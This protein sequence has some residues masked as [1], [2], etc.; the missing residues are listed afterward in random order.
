VD[1]EQRVVDAIR[2]VLT[3]YERLYPNVRWIAPSRRGGPPRNGESDL[4]L[5]SGERGMLLVI[6][7]K[8]GPIRRDGFGRWH[9]VGHDLDQSPFRQVETGAHALADKI[10]ANPDWRG[11]SLREVQAVAFPEVDRASVGGQND[12]G[13]DEPKALIL[14]REDLTSETATRAALDRMLDFWSGDGSRDRAFSEAQLA[15]ID[16]VLS[17]DVRLRPMLRGDIEAGEREM[18]SPTHHQLKLLRTLGGERRASIVGGAGSGKTLIAMEKVRRLAREGFNVLFV[19]FNQP[20]ARAFAGD[21][22]V[23][24]LA[25]AGRVTASTFHELC[26]QLGTE[27]GTLPPKP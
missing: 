20:L 4:V 12:L 26:I 1:Q 5:V 15:T 9:I 17:P 23:A 16:D 6:E 22:D 21:P 14:D 27:A 25:A 13:P 18:Y 7:T 2:A 8:S 19:C 24:P 11:A 10:R 3:P